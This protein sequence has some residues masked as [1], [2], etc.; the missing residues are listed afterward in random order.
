MCAEVRERRCWR[1]GRDVDK[2]TSEDCPSMDLK[3]EQTSFLLRAEG[4]PMRGGGWRYSRW[5]SSFRFKSNLPVLGPQWSHLLMVA[6]ILRLPPCQLSLPLFLPHRLLPIE[7][8]SLS[9][10]ETYGSTWLPRIEPHSAN[11]GLWGSFVTW[12]VPWVLPRLG[13]L[14]TRDSLSSLASGLWLSFMTCFL[15]LHFFFLFLPSLLLSSFLPPLL[16]FLSAC[17]CL[18]LRLS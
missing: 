1:A 16:P 5:S 3:R 14:I 10:L 18:S 6:S 9:C 12:H 13:L 17:L 7:I 4:V 15:Y 11:E 2:A 8:L